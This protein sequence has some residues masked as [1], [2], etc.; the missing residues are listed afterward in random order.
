MMTK[1]R[2]QAMQHWFRAHPIALGLLTLTAKGLTALVYIIY[3]GTELWLLLQRDGRL[4]RCTLVPMLVFVGG[5]TLR[6]SINAPRPYEV[7]GI[8]PLVSKET[9]GQS[10]PSRHVF[11]GSVIA[12][13]CL[14]LN[15]PLGIFTATIA[16]L[17]AASRVL[18][19][20][21]FPKDVIAGLIF[22][23]S[24]GFLGFFVL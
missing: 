8:P 3:V 19:G 10:F 18:T 6:R 12:V 9:K 17:I 13:S 21:H 5:S 11:C 7:F 22:G 2:Y 20:V 15:R 24:A 16:L 1:E 23:F 14:W 4:V